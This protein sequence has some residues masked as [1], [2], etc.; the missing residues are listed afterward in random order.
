MA[1]WTT[2]CTMAIKQA[3]ERLKMISLQAD[4]EAAAADP[5]RDWSKEVET[6]AKLAT[7]PDKVR[8]ALAI[9][10]KLHGARPIVF[11]AKYDPVNKGGS[12]GMIDQS[13][14][15]KVNQGGAEAWLGADDWAAKHGKHETKYEGSA[16]TDS[17][18]TFSAVELSP[19]T[20]EKQAL[21][22]GKEPKPNFDGLKPVV[23]EA[24][25][26][27]LHTSSLVTCERLSLH[28][29]WSMGYEKVDRLRA[30]VAGLS[31]GLEF[32]VE[33]E[34]SEWFDFYALK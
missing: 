20:F 1:S 5:T 30:K 21:A 26:T 12:M 2:G 33:M 23:A 19:K 28:V 27:L 34:Y 25:R 31:T 14:V 8:D 13:L 29:K 16:Y 24:L 10:D 18:W 22:T 9:P 17:A 4:A 6:A 32:I 11:E 7:I 3:E 15:V